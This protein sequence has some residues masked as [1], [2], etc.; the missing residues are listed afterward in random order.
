M[1]GTGYLFTLIAVVGVTV[2]RPPISNNIRLMTA[3]SSVLSFRMQDFHKI[4]GSCF[5]DGMLF[6]F[7]STSVE[8]EEAVGAHDTPN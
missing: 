4:N 5:S 6:K 7:V 2:T 8:P 1:N 3:W